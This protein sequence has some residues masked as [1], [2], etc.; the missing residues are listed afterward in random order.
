MISQDVH[1]RPSALSCACAY[2]DA[3]VIEQVLP[4][5]CLSS[6]VFRVK[7]IAVDARYIDPKSML[8]IRYESLKGMSERSELVPF[9]YINIQ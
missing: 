4:Q 8:M 3:L 2:V 6:T 5:H 9:N 7:K 1:V